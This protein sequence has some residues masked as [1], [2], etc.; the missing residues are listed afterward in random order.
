M[1]DDI[2]KKYGITSTGDD[3]P[4]VSKAPIK[5]EIVTNPLLDKYGITASPS[6]KQDDV[7]YKNIKDNSLL[8]STKR[9]GI[10]ALRG[11]KDVIDT[12][13]HGLGEAA[14]YASDKILPK[15]ISSEVRKSVDQMKLSDMTARKDYEKEYN[16]EDISAANI[17]RMGGQIAA[18]LPLTPMRAMEG[19]AAATKALPYVNRY[20]QKVAAPIVNR[21]TAATGQG[22]LGGALFNAA[23]SEA[24]DKSL[25]QN[26]GEGAITGA[27]GGPVIAGAGNLAKSVGKFAAGKIDPFKA[28]LAKKAQALGINLDASQVSDNQ[29]LKKYSQMMGVF[30]MTGRAGKQDDQLSQITRIAAKQ[31]GEDTDKITP[32]VIANAKK[33]LG[34]NYETVAASTN[35]TAD[36]DL[37]IA[38]AKAKSFAEMRLKD[39]DLKVFNKQLDNIIDSYGKNHGNLSGSRWQE[40]RKTKGD[41]GG[42]ISAYNGKP[43]QE[44]LKLLR[45]AVDDSFNKYAPA[46]MRRL[47]QDTNYQYGNM[48]TLEPLANKTY[49]GRINPL[50][51][52][53]AVNKSYRGKK[54]GNDVMTDLAD[55]G[56]A[57]FRQPADS[58][59]P[60]GNL[61]LD[62][63]KH[64]MTNPLSGGAALATS[65]LY[66]SAIPHALEV[67][68]GVAGN[69]ALYRAVNSAA[70]KKAII[71]ASQGAT[72][73]AI[74]DIV[75]RAT[76]YAGLTHITVRPSLK[77]MTTQQD[78]Q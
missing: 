69:A 25:A 6:E 12:L 38:L 45:D 29:L 64:L 4:S 67:G 75:N 23:T 33:R 53:G 52:T 32:Q 63:A 41:L 46:D 62:T 28:E 8:G 13:A 78:Q 76:P 73:G 74:D 20:G 21:L 10:G 47:L 30:P 9:F 15:S 58:G 11:G 56:Q 61:V 59:T 50:L 70:A 72:H 17:G 5:A 42:A 40:I 51:L 35:M 60:H 71:N 34:D 57:F 48:K 54:P 36:R 19:I 27:I 18:T 43:L 1:S 3:K 7:W 14:S 26:V 16:P 49:N 65:M 22:A 39:D 55:I 24:N 2:L 44:P 31:M 77:D 37:A 66:G 68:A